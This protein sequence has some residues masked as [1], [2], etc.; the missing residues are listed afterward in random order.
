[1][2]G[3]ER[4]SRPRYWWYRNVCAAIGQFPALRDRIDDLGRQSVTASVSGMP[5][6]SGVGRP[7]EGAALRAVCARE[8]DDY[9]AVQ[10]AI[11]TAEEWEDGEMVLDIVKM[12]HWLRVKNFDYIADTLHIGRGTAQRKNSKFVYEVAKNMGYFE[13]MG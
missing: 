10:R 12:W 11:E 5:H 2:D 13:I 3:G 4:V 6:G 7:V 1:M 9:I 8:Y